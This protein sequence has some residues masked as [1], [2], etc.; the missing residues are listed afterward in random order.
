MGLQK[1]YKGSMSLIKQ[2]SDSVEATPANYQL[3]APWDGRLTG[4]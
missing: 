2:C 3:P 4:S 1:D